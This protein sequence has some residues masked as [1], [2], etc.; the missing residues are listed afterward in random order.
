M[1]RILSIGCSELAQPID[2]RLREGGHLIVRDGSEAAAEADLVLL[3][4]SDD[5]RHARSICA[6]LRAGETALPIVSAA[7]HYAP[8]VERALLQA[9]ADDHWA[10]PSALDSLVVRVELRSAPSARLRYRIGAIE[11]D[12]RRQDAFVERR[13]CGLT[14]REYALLAMLARTPGAVVTR[15][16]VLERW[17]FIH[18][19][20]SNLV[21][22]HVARLRGKLGAGG[23]QIET[24]RGRGLRLRTYERA[25]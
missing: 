22:V 9:G 1:C 11:L 15:G 4:V 13:A 21:D 23:A 18:H 2:A 24:V 17:G 8:E 14:R 19:G 3:H 25:L 5:W 10:P 20:G 6:E 16:E 12:E 7:D